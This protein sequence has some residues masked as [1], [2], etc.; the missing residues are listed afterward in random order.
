VRKAAPIEGLKASL[1]RRTLHPAVVKRWGKATARDLPRTLPLL[2]L[3]VGDLRLFC[4]KARVPLTPGLESA[5]VEFQLQLA[6][7]ATGR[8]QARRATP[9]AGG[10][11]DGIEDWGKG[12]AWAAA[13]ST[14]DR[15]TKEERADLFADVDRHEA[16]KENLER[17]E[18]P[19]GF[20]EI[21]V[22]EAWVRKSRTARLLARLSNTVALLETGAARVDVRRCASCAQ[23][24]V[25]VTRRSGRPPKDCEACRLRLTKQQRWYRRA[26]GRPVRRRGRRIIP[27]GRAGSV[28]ELLPKRGQK[29]RTE[30]KRPTTNRK[31]R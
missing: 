29:P 23:G 25:F 27:R 22:N 30:A 21:A 19:R 15:Y 14:A 13:V 26:V 31:D 6:N 16:K 5:R 2:S 8:T 1:R 28:A 12:Y 24:F 3:F 20:P 17:Q 4:A 7:I 9:W 18:E 10:D 11:W